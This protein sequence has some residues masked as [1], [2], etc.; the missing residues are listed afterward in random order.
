[1]PPATAAQSVS[2]PT[3]DEI[4]ETQMPNPMRFEP[5]MPGSGKALDEAQRIANMF[6]AARY[7]LTNESYPKGDEWKNEALVRSLRESGIAKL[8]SKIMLGAELG[9]S[10]SMAARSMHMIDGLPC[11]S[12]HMLVALVKARRDLC[13]YFRPIE[14]TAT[15]ATF[16]TWRVGDPEPVRLTV[17]VDDYKHLHSRD[18]WKYYR[19]DM[20]AARCKSALVHAVYEDAF[21]RVYSTEEVQDMVATRA[22]RA[23]GQDV[24]TPHIDAVLE[25]MGRE[26]PVSAPE[27]ERTS[28]V[29]PVAPTAAAAQAEPSSLTPQELKLLADA[30][31]FEG[32]IGDPITNP[33][34]GRP[35]CL[36]ILRQAAWLPADRLELVIAEMERR[37]AEARKA[38]GGGA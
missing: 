29:V 34:N 35:R 24:P 19:R 22:M 17:E 6:Y 32:S 26:D 13:K 10:A 37:L 1:M 2:V 3:I 8:T 38:A 16:E 5:G 21:C 25:N 12:A 7:G 31:R 15:K 33:L 28:V 27:P 23:S 30:Q 4:L 36:A 11:L 18:N 9:M 14:M 20:L